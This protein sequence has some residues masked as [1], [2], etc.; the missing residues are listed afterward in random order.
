M[1]L[2]NK[3]KENSSLKLWLLLLIWRVIINNI[4]NEICFLF[5]AHSH[6]LHSWYRIWKCVIV[7]ALVTVSLYRKYLSWLNN[8]VALFLLNLVVSILRLVPYLI[9][10]ILLYLCV[11]HVVNYI[12]LSIKLVLSFYIF[13]L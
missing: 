8:L 10:Y 1:I 2:N 3:I 5:F 11:I 7:R 9:W 13:H 6:C 12:L 4:L